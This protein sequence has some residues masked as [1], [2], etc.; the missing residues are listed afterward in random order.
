MTITKDNVNEVLQQANEGNVVVQYD[1]ATYYKSECDYYNALVWYIKAAEQGNEKALELLFAPI[2]I[3]DKSKIVEIKPLYVIKEEEE[4]RRKTTIL[5]LVEAVERHK[6]KEEEETKRIELER[7]RRLAEA[8]NAKRKAEEEAKRK[9]EEAKQKAAEE[10]ARRIEEEKA[11]QKAEEEARIKAEEEARRKA[12]EEEKNRQLIEYI[13]VHSKSKIQTLLDEM[14]YVEG[15]SVAMRNSQGEAYIAKIDDFYV[16]RNIVTPEDY[17][18]LLLQPK[19]YGSLESAQQYVSRLSEI[20]GYDFSLPS[21]EQLDYALHGGINYDNRF[22]IPA[23]LINSAKSTRVSDEGQER[24]LTTYKKS[25]ASFRIVCTDPKYMEKRRQEDEQKRRREEEE[26]AR[27]REEETRRQEE[28]RRREEEEK[29]RQEEEAR[30]KE[31]HEAQLLAQERSRL[32]PLL[33]G[34]SNEMLLVESGNVPVE[35]IIL[36]GNSPHTVR[37]EEFCIL[38]STINVEAVNIILGHEIKTD[39]FGAYTRETAEKLCVRLSKISGKE[40]SLPTVN[41]LEAAYNAHLWSIRASLCC[42]EWCKDK[43]D[44]KRTLISTKLNRP[45]P[46]VACFRFVTKDPEVIASVKEKNSWQNIIKEYISQRETHEYKHGII[47]GDKRNVTIVKQPLT[48]RVWKAVMQHDTLR[49]QNSDNL[50]AKKDLDDF[51]KRLNESDIDLSQ[52]DYLHNNPYA[53][54]ALSA[55]KVIDEKGVYLY[56][57][58]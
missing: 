2:E 7:I 51:L 58:D 34:L 18:T 5:A 4:I 23:P 10:E 38:Y 27:R 22:M 13:R 29:R 49:D 9:A 20:T 36:Q 47:F 24:T 14:V 19:N 43:N 28:A 33:E 15:K 17:E 30:L 21:Y 37:T 32:A 42:Y 1:L 46:A 3:E 52:F 35:K 53:Y 44:V 48:Y 45:A 25:N 57:K 31:E 6:R 54:G 55:R 40:F 39:K 26:E 16:K 56:L 8:A 11:Q 41:Q 12:E 50:V